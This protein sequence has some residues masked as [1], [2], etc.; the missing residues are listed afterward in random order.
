VHSKIQDLTPVPLPYTQMKVRI[1]L[2]AVFLILGWEVAFQLGRWNP[3][4][5]PHPL[6]I[7]KTLGRPHFLRALLRFALISFAPAV[8]FGGLAGLILGILCAPFS[9]LAHSMIRFLR[10]AQWLPFLLTW[11]LPIWPPQ[12]RF[13]IVD[14]LLI[15]L[16]NVSAVA[17]S[18]SYRYLIMRS[19]LKR[20]WR[21][22]WFDLGRYTA[23]RSLFI[24]L[25]AQIWLSPNG[26]DWFDMMSPDAANRG[27]AVLIVL[28]SLVFLI[29][30]IFRADFE[31]IASNTVAAI[32]N[33]RRTFNALSAWGAFFLG[34]LCLIMWIYSRK[35]VYSYAF[36]SYPSNIAATLLNILKPSAVSVINDSESIWS[37]SA[38]SLTVLSGGLAVGVG[39]A[40]L[41]AKSQFDNS[42][43]KR[44]A[45][46]IIPFTYVVPILFSLF[47]VIWLGIAPQSLRTGLGVALLS[48]Y[49][50]VEVLWGSV[51][52]PIRSR[53][54]L[55][56]AEALP[57]AFVALIV[58]D[59][60][61]STH[62]LS[63]LMI[64]GRVKSG[65]LVSSAAVA[66][67]VIILFLILSISLRWVGRRHWLVEQH[68]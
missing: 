33:E 42:V 50:A 17:L 23:L 5:I 11:A 52:Y 60:I 31:D 59:A 9:F 22:T 35:L 57:F 25:I 15:L 26:W 40:F 47:W 43:A 58:G 61:F 62:G 29:N 46:H 12:E 20:E 6:G 16:V 2:I 64:M 41:V 68:L 10:V 65:T 32:E 49:P 14:W 44:C 38:F 67:F 18:A 8:V 30:V 24:C 3:D 48:F 34:C 21:T 56:A 28:L 1:A 19:L 37:A 66:F 27:A 45:I 53:L 7:L 51:N 4:L 13:G 54:T 55:A 36:L 39:L 63:F